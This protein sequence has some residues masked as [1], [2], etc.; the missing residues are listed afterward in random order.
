M[1]ARL[2]FKKRH[3]LWGTKF[4]DGLS[5]AVPLIEMK[6]CQVTFP[7]QEVKMRE[8]AEYFMQVSGYCVR[9]GCSMMYRLTISMQP[10]PSADFVE[11]NVR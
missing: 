8:A 2:R 6:K 1:F 4:R 10:E 9:V 7:D 5:S 11:V 3:G